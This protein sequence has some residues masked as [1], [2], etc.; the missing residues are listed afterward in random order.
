MQKLIW[1]KDHKCPRNCQ[2]NGICCLSAWVEVEVQTLL[3]TT[4][5]YGGQ[6]L[7]RTLFTRRSTRPASVVGVGPPMANRCL[8]ASDTRPLAYTHPSCATEKRTLYPPCKQEK[9]FSNKATNPEKLWWFF[10]FWEVNVPTS[11][12]IFMWP[13]RGWKTDHVQK[14]RL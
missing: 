4:F 2:A 6:A 1:I 3:P 14:M 12:L 5:W 8:Q 7:G 10:N 9:I 13:S 11:M